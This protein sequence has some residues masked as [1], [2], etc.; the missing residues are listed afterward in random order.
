MN[1]YLAGPMRGV[2]DF[3]APAFAQAAATLRADH[4]VVFNPAERD[5]AEFGDVLTSPTGSER[6]LA[7]KTGMST[8][9][10]RREVFLADMTWICQHADA[11]A[12]LPGWEQSKGATAEHALAIALGLDVIYL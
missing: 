12:L 5:Q 4:H 6:T 7:R 2:K 10:L 3:N 1:Y 11:I 9:A 8:M